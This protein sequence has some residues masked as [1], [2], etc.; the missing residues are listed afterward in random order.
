MIVLDGNGRFLIPKR[1]L[2]M[3][4]INQQIKFI[5][6]DDCIEIWNNESEE[7]FLDPDDFSAALETVMGDLGE[8]KALFIKE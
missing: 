6:M 5:G 3:A 4:N 7:S 8:T 1:Y 2:K